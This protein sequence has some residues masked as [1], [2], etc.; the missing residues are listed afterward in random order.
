M[1]E[2]RAI[3]AETEPFVWSR[4]EFRVGR[5]SNTEHSNIGPLAMCSP[6]YQA[7]A[8]SLSAFVNE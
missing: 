7:L 8:E 6:M 1:N 5:S 2:A 4:D 3:L